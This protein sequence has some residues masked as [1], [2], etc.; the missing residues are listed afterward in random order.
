MTNTPPAHT[1]RAI[2][3]HTLFVRE[4]AANHIAP[5]QM[6][7]CKTSISAHRNTNDPVRHY[8]YGVALEMA[9]QSDDADEKYVAFRVE[10]ERLFGDLERG[11]V[12]YAAE[13]EAF[14]GDERR[15]EHYE[16]MAKI[17]RGPEP[18]ADARKRGNCVVA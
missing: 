14:S 8:F 3:R 15:R 2:T 13:A 12:H 4:T 5:S 17:M 10:A 18:G 6:V 9:G 16:K 7:G 11:A 1:E